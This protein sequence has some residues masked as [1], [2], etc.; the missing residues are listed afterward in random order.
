MVDLLLGIPVKTVTQ[1]TIESLHSAISFKRIASSLNVSVFV[2]LYTEAENFSSLKKLFNHSET[3]VDLVCCPARGIYPAFNRIYADSICGLFKY[4]MILGDDD[5]IAFPLNLVYL[6]NRLQKLNSIDFA[7]TSILI[8]DSIF[9][10]RKR[11]SYYSLIFNIDKMRLNHP[12]MLVATKFIK[13][14]NLFFSEYFGT[15]GDYDWVLRAFKLKPN[16]INIHELTVFHRLGGASSLNTKCT[17]KDHL[18]CI[19]SIKN[20][21]SQFYLIALILRSS[22]FALRA[23]IRLTIK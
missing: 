15:V 16:V 2:K 19:R 21:F 9:S 7:C 8:G 14:N 3:K 5:S 22:R 4:V 13:D 20:N 10:S 11:K 6:I 18:Y 1:L 17:V 12:G 23:F